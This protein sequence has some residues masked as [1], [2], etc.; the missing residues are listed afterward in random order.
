M[1]VTRIRD[2]AVAVVAATYQAGS[3]PTVS[4]D[5]YVLPEMEVRIRRR[6]A[7]QL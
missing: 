6:S 5:G 1:A 2:D 3:A 4:D 7:Y